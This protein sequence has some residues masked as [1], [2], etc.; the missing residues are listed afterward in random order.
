M[1]EVINELHFMCTLKYVSLTNV[2]TIRQGDNANM[3][4]KNKAVS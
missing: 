1:N 2:F 3:T 4:I